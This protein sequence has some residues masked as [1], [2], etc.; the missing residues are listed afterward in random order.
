MYSSQR[1][2]LAPVC[3]T[4][5]GN[6]VEFIDTASQVQLGIATSVLTCQEKVM[7]DISQL[8]QLSRLYLDPNA[9]SSKLR[10]C[11]AI[12]VVKILNDLVISGHHRYVA[13]SAERSLR[14]KCLN[15]SHIPRWPCVPCNGTAFDMVWRLTEKMWNFGRIAPNPTRNRSMSLRELE[16]HWA[17]KSV[18]T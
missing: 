8:T 1:S 3:S 13:V 9:C 12:F 7:P 4:R 5:P 2:I 15:L 18:T 14:F 10:N 16:L 17:V 11:R 6:S